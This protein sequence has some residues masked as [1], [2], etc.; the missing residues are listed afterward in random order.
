MSSRVNKYRSRKRRR[1][2]GQSNQER[3]AKAIE[4]YRPV[5]KVDS[6]RV[7]AA[8][9]ILF[10]AEHNDFAWPEVNNIPT[11][12]RLQILSPV[13]VKQKYANGFEAGYSYRTT[14][15]EIEA[16]FEGVAATSVEIGGVSV[17]GFT[18]RRK[19][20][21]LNVFGERT[22]EEQKEAKRVLADSGVRGI[23]PKEQKKTVL[24]RIIVARFD[25]HVP[26]MAEI[27]ERPK[28][29]WIEDTPCLSSE[30]LAISVETHLA[31]HEITSL[32]LGEVVVHS[33]KS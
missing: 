22:A 25:D 5:H 24:S 20:L 1:S 32:R 26:S 13:Y 9:A 12:H 7:A 4:V 11:R 8:L 16:R 6:G 10:D 15:S 29:F 19:Y 21:G 18:R 2:Y 27:S 31:A 17:F 33:V 23:P 30:D 14:M 28:K 3:R